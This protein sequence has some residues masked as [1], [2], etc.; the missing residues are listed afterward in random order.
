MVLVR[1]PTCRL[2]CGSHLSQVH[3]PATTTAVTV[4]E[5]VVTELRRRYDREPAALDYLDRINGL[6]RDQHDA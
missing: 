3:V 1:T 4:T 6:A 2:R 5:E